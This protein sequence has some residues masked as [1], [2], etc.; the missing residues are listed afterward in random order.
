MFI[1]SNKKASFLTIE[2]LLII[3]LLSI[4]SYSIFPKKTDAN[5]KLA[6]DRLELY[7]NHTRFKAFIDD[8]YDLE[9]PL[10][11]KKRWTLKFL[12][13]RK[14]VGGLYYV[15]YSDKNMSGHPSFDDALTDPLTKRKV[16][17][18]NFCKESDKNSK[19]V[20]LTQTFGI[21]KVELSCNDTS[22]IGQLSF[23]SDGRVYT[24][25]SSNEN[26]F[27]EYE[28]KNE[29]FIKFIG[30]ENKEKTLKIVGKTGFIEQI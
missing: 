1:K 8:K 22:S 12:N 18:S 29:C 16:Y 23:G 20:L 15:I 17:S 14:S 21:K 26:E 9:N 3:T 28:L 5:L 7:L 24:K 4:I 11:H 27:Y 13:C 25:L 6:V 30:K 10:W 2:I 19:F